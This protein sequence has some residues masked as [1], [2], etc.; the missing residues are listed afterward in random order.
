[1]FHTPPTKN[2]REWSRE[3]A[4]YSYMDPASTELPDVETGT[5][6]A[7]AAGGAA[8]GADGGS[9]EVETPE[10]DTTVVE[11]ESSATASPHAPAAGPS[12]PASPAIP[13]FVPSTEDDILAFQS[14]LDSFTPE[15][16]PAAIRLSV[17]AFAAH[18]QEPRYVTPLLPEEVLRMF[19]EFYP[20]HRNVVAD[21]LQRPYTPQP[22]SLP[23]V[24]RQEMACWAAMQTHAE[25]MAHA[26]V[27]MTLLSEQHLFSG[28]YKRLFMFR[29]H[30]APEL[31][32]N[33]NMNRKL[34]RL[35]QQPVTLAGL[36]AVD[37]GSSDDNYPEVIHD[38]Q[39]LLELH[40]APSVAV[41]RQ[42]PDRHTPRE[43]LEVILQTHRQVAA[44]LEALKC[45]GGHVL[46]DH[47]LPLLMFLFIYSGVENLFLHFL[48]IKRFYAEEDLHG[49][50]SY[51][52]TNFEAILVYLAS[53]TLS[54]LGLPPPAQPEFGDR[55]LREPLDYEQAL[56]MASK[57]L[58][59]P[60]TPTT[61]TQFRL[62]LRA[63]RLR[64][65]SNRSV[66]L[67]D[68]REDFT[69]AV[70]QAFDLGLRNIVGRFSR[71]LLTLLTTSAEPAVRRR[72]LSGALLATTLR[73]DEP[74]LRAS[75]SMGSI[76]AESGAAVA[77][78]QPVVPEEPTTMGRLNDMFN[79]LGPR[80]P[81]STPAAPLLR[82]PSERPA[83]RHSRASLLI[84]R[85]GS[86]LHNIGTPR[87]EYSPVALHA[88]GSTLL[89]STGE[90]A[91]GLDAR[92]VALDTTSVFSSR[93]LPR[94]VARYGDELRRFEDLTVAELTEMY[95][96][97]RQLVVH[98]ESQEGFED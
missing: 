21:A 24:L 87:E 43:K 68:H 96:M 48:F 97:Y 91:L 37:S 3:A 63:N 94:L 69:S 25:L 67:G 88:G 11:P 76:S 6:G 13:Q 7:A 72:E 31:L 77:T 15:D 64:S 75:P 26:V 81:T 80:P 10:G 23:L 79:R 36:F 45:S 20:H 54:E 98:V 60:Q 35:S 62:F 28:L 59:T 47:L 4:K 46:N 30:A 17:E 22:H 12:A 74:Q 50:M 52:L 90:D 82:T 93:K 66:L 2:D 65:N 55:L 84:D 49:E 83:T 16:L 57:A 41:L 70:G 71:A 40:L 39:T 19:Q 95:D 73:E 58:A 56:R 29:N 38:T 5:E 44:D 1:M 18:L 92:K 61:A 33:T 85:L 34:A 86:T 27:R 78:P 89:L 42:L 51:L 53:I 32:F 8:G 14:Y 9:A